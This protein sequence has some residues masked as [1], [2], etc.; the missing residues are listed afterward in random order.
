[1]TPAPEPP[2]PTFVTP[3]DLAGLVIDGLDY[4]FAPQ[5]VI[6]AGPSIGAVGRLGEI[7][8]VAG[9][10]IDDE[11]AGFRIEAGRAIVGEA[12]FVGSNQAAVRRRLLGGIR[13]GMAFLVDAQC[14]VHR[15][16]GN[17][18]E[19]LAIGAVEDKEVAVARS[20]HE[21]LARLAVEVGVDKY[22]R[23]DCVPIMRVVRRD[24]KAPDEFSRVGIERDDA[25]GVEIRR[26]G[27]VC[28]SGREWD[29]QCPSRGDSDPGRRCRSSRSCRRL[30]H[31][32]FR[33]EAWR[34][35]ATALRRF[36]DRRS[37]GSR[38]DCRDRRPTPAIT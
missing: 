10:G 18:E 36:L 14:P 21:H 33:W 6:G 22:R 37:A 7:D 13:N 31:S 9:M 38:E 27:A 28:R 24:R 32:A 25:A 11:Q 30:W 29:C 8:A 2:S 16:K 5:A 4:T 3:A 20:L 26:R 1:M 34:P 15:A 23:F 17:G 35:T 19:A 12:A